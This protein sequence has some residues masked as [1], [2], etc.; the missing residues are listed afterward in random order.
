MTDPG[1]PDPQIVSLRERID[2]LDDELLRLINERAAIARRV[3]EIKGEGPVYRPEREA[4][5]L[6][7]L[8]AANPGPLPAEAV[9][10]VYTEL[11][12]ACRAVEAPLAVAFLGPRGTFSEEAA[13]RRFGSSIQAAPCGSI[14]EVF[15]QVEARQVDFGVVPVENSSE[16]AVG[17]TLDLLLATPALISG[18][19]LLPVH[20]CLMGKADALATVR[21]VYAHEQAL[22]QCHEWLSQ[23]LPRA[24]RIAMVSN[25]EAARRAAEEGD[26]AALGSHTAAALYALTVLARNI[27]DNPNNT[28]RFAVIGHLAAPPSG[29]DKTSLVMSARNRPGAMHELLQ[30]LADQGVS[31]SRLESRPS[32]TGMWEYVFFVDL[33]G[34]QQDPNVAAALDELRRRASF[35]KILGSYPAA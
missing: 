21:R 16:G 17:R 19:V 13:A 23:N 27:E 20:H 32:R 2:A 12:S 33:E 3:G 15:R 31:M 1:N 30:P 10:R 9:A 18:E 7:R 4:Q 29:R 14:E 28:T 6:R 11:I 22:G 24:E 5:I 25:A 34:H 26:S 8:Q 35:L